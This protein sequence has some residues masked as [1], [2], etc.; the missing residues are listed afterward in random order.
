M[1]VITIFIEG[2][3]LEHENQTIQTLDN[4][5]R[6]RESFYKL[7]IQEFKETDFKLE[8]EIGGPNLQT[9]KFLKEALENN[10][11]AFGLIDLDVSNDERQ[12][13]IKELNLSDQEVVERVIFMVQEMESWILS[14]PEKIEQFYT[15]LKRRSPHKKLEDDDTLK[16]IH[17]EEISS[18]SRKIHVLLGRYFMIEK[19]GKQ[20]K[21]KYNKLKDGADLLELLDYHKL[22]T[23]FSDVKRLSDNLKKKN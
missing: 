13:K 11:Y 19:K 9:I 2:G 12:N 14:Q 4:S 17:P 23:T 8:V 3:V 18:P 1:A 22:K 20:K 5:Q 7:L 6:L 10:K 16:N 21:K 15:N